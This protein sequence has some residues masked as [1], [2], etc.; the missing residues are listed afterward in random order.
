MT[1]IERVLYVAGGVGVLATLSWVV[2]G[3]GW[4]PGN[5]VAGVLSCASVAAGALL[6]AL[7]SPSNDASH[8]PVAGDDIVQSRIRAEGAVVAKSGRGRS[9]RD[10]IRQ[11]GIRAGGDVIGTQETTPPPPEAAP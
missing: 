6:R 3:Q 7:A 2:L 10:R 8:P 11:R 4:Q 5:A 1:T 9:G